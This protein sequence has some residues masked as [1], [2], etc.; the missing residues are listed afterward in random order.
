MLGG[1]LLD[2]SNDFWKDLLGEGDDNGD[3]EISFEEFK[4][5]MKKLF[6]K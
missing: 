4:L 1:D 6:L 5:M 3:G 2:V